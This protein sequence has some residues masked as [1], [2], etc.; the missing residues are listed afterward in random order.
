MSLYLE[1]GEKE[2]VFY[3]EETWKP[4]HAKKGATFFWGLEEGRYFW[5]PHD[6]NV[7]DESFL[8]KTTAILQHVETQTKEA[9]SQSCAIRLSSK[10]HP[11]HDVF[12]ENHLVYVE[13]RFRLAVLAAMSSGYGINDREMFTRMRTSRP[14]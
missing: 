9:K 11:A 1:N 6:Q 3:D 13:F 5:H 4:Q 10:S 12:T 8:C 7:N 2:F 14:L